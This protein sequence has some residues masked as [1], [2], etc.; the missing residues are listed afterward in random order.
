MDS[1]LFKQMDWL[2]HHCFHKALV[3][4]GHSFVGYMDIWDIDRLATLSFSGKERT[5]VPSISTKVHE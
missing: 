5:E 1:N 3:F 2:Q 4:P